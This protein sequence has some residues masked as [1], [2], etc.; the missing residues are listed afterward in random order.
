L[1]L[2]VA[3]RRKRTTRERRRIIPLRIGLRRLPRT[4]EK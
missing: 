3:N 1:L 4:S 2:L